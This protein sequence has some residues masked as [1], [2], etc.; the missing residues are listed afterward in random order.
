MHRLLILL[1]LLP[2][3]CQFP[4]DVDGTLERVRGGVL[5]AGVVQSAP[6]TAVEMDLV[7]GFARTLDAEVKWVR[8]AESELIEALNGGQLDVVV[9]G[10]TRDSAHQKEVTLTR[11]YATSQVI[12]AAPPGGGVPE[13]L[14]GV[15][16]GV[17]AH[18]AAA[19]ELERQ[20]DADPVPL[21]DIRK[22]D[23]P[24]AVEDH[25]VDDLGYEG[26]SRSLSESE[27][28]FAV[29]HGEN[30][31]LTELEFFLLDRGEEAMRALQA[32]DEP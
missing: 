13:D 19:T 17:E 18:S 11:P 9:G 20:T 10:L 30:A 14:D 28:V 23:G 7:K 15:R 29:T 3:G 25:L 4:R 16:V 8:G 24:V 6:W 5:R 27:H 12:F 26:T 21:E 2:A 22:F 32:E 1:L 31:F